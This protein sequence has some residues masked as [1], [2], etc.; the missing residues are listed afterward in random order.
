MTSWPTVLFPRTTSGSV[1][2][3]N[4][5]SLKPAAGQSETVCLAPTTP[6]A[7]RKFLCGRPERQSV[8][9]SL[10]SVASWKM[11]RTQVQ[12]P[13]RLKHGA[14]I[15]R[16]QALSDMPLVFWINANKVGVERSMMALRK[17]KSMGYRHIAGSRP[18]DPDERAGGGV[19]CRLH[20]A[21]SIIR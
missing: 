13:A 17:R 8:A 1:L 6:G 5:V 4:N 21:V 14:I 18:A 15:L 10:V 7:T 12:A 9:V 2:R 20:S 19:P 3:R 11:Q 16:S